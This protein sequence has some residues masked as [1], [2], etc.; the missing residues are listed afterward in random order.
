MCDVRPRNLQRAFHWR[1]RARVK[2]QRHSVTSRNLDQS[3]CCL[4]LAK[5]IR[6]PNDLVERVEQSPLLIYYELGV[7]DDVDEQD[8]ANLELNFLF[9]L[10]HA[11]SLRYTS[12]GIL[13]MSPLTV[14]AKEGVQFFSNA[15]IW[16]PI[17]FHADGRSSRSVSPQPRLLRLVDVRE[18][19][20][21][22]V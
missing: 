20:K 19:S 21:P 18:P 8:M 17:V 2:N 9:N 14:E 16:F 6:A 22:S 1:F 13:S 12:P 5:F 11:E 3:S 7:T 15:K 10:G 4:G